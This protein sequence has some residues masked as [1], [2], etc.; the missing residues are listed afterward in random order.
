MSAIQYLPLAAPH[1][2]A[3]L[4]IL[5]FISRSVEKIRDEENRGKTS[6][7][8][9]TTRSATQSERQ[10]QL[11]IL[12][13]KRSNGGLGTKQKDQDFLAYI[14]VASS[15]VMALCAGLSLRFDASTPIATTLG[16]QI[17]FGMGAAVVASQLALS[18]YN[19]TAMLSPPAKQE[20]GKSREENMVQPNLA[21][22]AE[23]VG[24]SIGTAAAQAI[25]TRL[26]YK[27][28]D[29]S[30][31]Y[32]DATNFMIPRA[33][34]I[35]EPLTLGGQA[36]TLERA[37]SIEATDVLSALGIAGIVFATYSVYQKLKRQRG[38]SLESVADH[39]PKPEPY[40]VPRI[41]LSE[42]SDVLRRRLAYSVR[43]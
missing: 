12:A 43:S 11:A 8:P 13:N 42:P 3:C 32:A 36:S 35:G 19:W 34:S 1:I 27:R 21:I 10:N 29:E 9:R 28:M 22:F 4:L 2:L 38:T 33:E 17:L 20:G 6:K 18:G 14:L 7:A 25:Y 16:M 40:E 5:L 26:L 24:G 39:P 41:P 23:M 37:F 15:C 30:K 31:Y